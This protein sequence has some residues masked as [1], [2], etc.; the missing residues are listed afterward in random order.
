MNLS[1]NCITHYTN[2]FSKLTKL[3]DGVIYGSYCKE[4]LRYN[5]EVIPRF[6]PMISF[7]DMPIKTYTNVSS[8]YGKFGISLTKKWATENKLTPVLYIDKNSRLI[9]NLVTSM[10]NSLTTLNIANQILKQNPKN[11]Q[12]TKNITKS[13]EYLS[14]SLMYTKHYEDEL[15]REDF[16]NPNYRFYDEREWRYIPEF[17]CAVCELK[18]TEEEFI[19]WRGNTKNKPILNQVKLNFKANDIENI[20]VENDENRNLLIEVIKKSKLDFTDTSKEILISKILT[21]KQIEQNL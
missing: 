15:E 5:G 19:T 11:I 13:L 9:D 6:I 21:I 10:K 20:I 3:L 12:I 2:E 1:S 7:C 4:I 8:P 17:D 16:Y 14:Y 18:Q